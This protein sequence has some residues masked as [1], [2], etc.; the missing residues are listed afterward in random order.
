LFVRFYLP[1]IF[2]DITISATGKSNNGSFYYPSVQPRQKK[3]TPRPQIPHNRPRISTAV[4]RAH[5]PSASAASPLT[6][7]QS[8]CS[9]RL[10][11]DKGCDGHRSISAPP[12]RCVSRPLPPLGSRS[13]RAGCVPAREAAASPSSG[14][15]ARSEAKRS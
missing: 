2:M 8:S 9:L 11:L 1:L 6:S 14:A 5:A 7:A 3:N 4:D 15:R 12:C 13:E 10:H